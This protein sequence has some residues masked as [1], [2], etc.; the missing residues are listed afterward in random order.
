MCEEIFTYPQNL[1]EHKEKRT[2]IK[3]IILMQQVLKFPRL[4]SLL[5]KT[6]CCC[7]H[8]GISAS[9]QCSLVT[10]PPMGPMGP[11]TS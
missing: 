9:I 7:R 10:Q 11:D 1:K 3:C 4:Y 2:R 8:T 5:P 6:V